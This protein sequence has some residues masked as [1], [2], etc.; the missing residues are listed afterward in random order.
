MSPNGRNILEG[1][2]TTNKQNIST[3]EE[4]TNQNTYV[5]NDYTSGL[6]WCR[7]LVHRKHVISPGNTCQYRNRSRK[8]CSWTPDSC[9]RALRIGSCRRPVDRW[10]WRRTAQSDRGAGWIYWCS[11]LRMNLIMKSPKNNKNGECTGV[12]PKKQ[13]LRVNLLV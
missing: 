11:P 6:I 2:T 4:I 8:I 3:W 13:H 9:H 7:P 10:R 1:R 12:V 5:K